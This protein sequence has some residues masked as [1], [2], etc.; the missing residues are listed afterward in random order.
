MPLG[1]SLPPTALGGADSGGYRQASR[2]VV[3]GAG[4]SSASSASF[5]RT[6][7]RTQTKGALP[8]GRPGVLCRDL[9]VGRVVPVERCQQRAEPAGAVDAEKSRDVAEAESHL[10][11]E[12]AG[13]LPETAVGFRRLG[14]HDA[15]AVASFRGGRGCG[16]GETG[17]D[18]GRS[19]EGE[20]ASTCARVNLLVRRRPEWP[21]ARS[22]SPT[23]RTDCCRAAVSTCRT[24]T[25]H[26][27]DAPTYTASR[28]R[29]Q[30]RSTSVIRTTA[31][32]SSSEA[33]RSTSPR[34]RQS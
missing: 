15:P 26:A 27:E 8:N 28:P 3:R 34:M 21:P 18:A 2:Q 32:P 23:A 12:R 30:R 22:S 25:G 4:S 5:C 10:A 6:A 20:R 29:A 14:G 33:A 17:N 24:R 31:A 13:V 1:P 11:R 16:Q 9:A 7:R 19:G